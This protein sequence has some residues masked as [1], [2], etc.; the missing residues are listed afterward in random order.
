MSDENNLLFLVAIPALGR[1]L[2]LFFMAAF[3]PDVE[4]VL[5]GAGHG[6]VVRVG[7]FAM[8]LETA[9]DIIFARCSVMTDGA[10]V[11]FRVGLVWKNNRGLFSLSFVDGNDI[12]R[13]AMGD[14]D[15]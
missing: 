10:I 9:L 7:I 14:R 1:A 2:G 11:G 4:G 5:R 8:A 6:W 12:R 3:T 13:V 15:Q